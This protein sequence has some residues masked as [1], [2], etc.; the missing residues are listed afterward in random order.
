MPL[1]VEDSDL[2]GVNC[3]EEAGLIS[4]E[5][6]QIAELSWL[7]SE[8]EVGER[9]GRFYKSLNYEGINMY[10]IK[11]VQELSNRVRILENRI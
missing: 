4:Q 9:T 2:S 1:G 3:F 10:L 11:A 6:E 8:T 5:V 7:V